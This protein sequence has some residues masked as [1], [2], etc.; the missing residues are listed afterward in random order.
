MLDEILAATDDAWHLPDRRRGGGPALDP[1]PRVDRMWL[2]DDRTVEFGCRD[3]QCQ[4]DAGRD[5]APRMIRRIGQSCTAVVAWATEDLI[6][7]NPDLV[8]RFVAATLEAAQYLKDHPAYA[9]DR[10]ARQR[11]APKAL[12]HQV[13]AARLTQSLSPDGRGSGGDLVA[14]VAGNWKFM[15]E[16]GAV[17]ASTAVSIE[18]VVD[19][20]LL[21]G[22]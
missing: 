11:N 20:R 18:D 21:P 22:R 14:A 3:R 5:F 19:A 4:G 12:A 16:S 8:R 1:A 10:Y 2:S 13:A 7:A 15:T 9:S 17:P 6:A